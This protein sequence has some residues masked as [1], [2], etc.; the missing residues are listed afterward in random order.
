MRELTELIKEVDEE[1][2]RRDAI[3]D[4]SFAYPSVK[5]SKEITIKHVGATTSVSGARI[6]FRTKTTQRRKF[7]ERR[8]LRDL[9]FEIG[10]FLCVNII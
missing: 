5:K 9:S 1:A 4:F 2:R 3:L 6:D 8:T 7:N 10:D